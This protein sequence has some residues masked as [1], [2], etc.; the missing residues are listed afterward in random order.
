VLILLVIAAVTIDFAVMT[1]GAFRFNTDE[2]IVG[3]HTA[4]RPDDPGLVPAAVVPTAAVSTPPVVAY[5]PRARSMPRRETPAARSRLLAF[6]DSDRS[7][8]DH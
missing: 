2:S 5:A 7:S 3:V 6:A 4:E 1:A 8:E